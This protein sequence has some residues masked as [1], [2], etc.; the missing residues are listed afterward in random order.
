MMTRI[1]ILGKI[2]ETKLNNYL[3]HHPLEAFI[4]AFIGIPLGILLGASFLAIFFA[5]PLGII[6]GWF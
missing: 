5:C 2:L 3:L 1:Q 6:L 4:F